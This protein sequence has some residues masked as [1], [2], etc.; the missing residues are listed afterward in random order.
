[1]MAIPIVINDFTTS[2][3]N[4]I[5]KNETCKNSYFIDFVNSLDTTKNFNTDKETIIRVMVDEKLQVE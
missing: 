1:M 3:G 5:L 2:F 4:A